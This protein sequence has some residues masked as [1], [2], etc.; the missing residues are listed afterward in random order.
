MILEFGGTSH[1]TWALRWDIETSPRERFHKL[2]A[3]FD[4][5]AQE[6]PS[7]SSNFSSEQRAYK[8]RSLVYP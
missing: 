8:Q 3:G 1:S 5:T 7:V 6:S 2:N 4:Y